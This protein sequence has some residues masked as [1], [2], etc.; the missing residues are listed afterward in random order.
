MKPVKILVPVDFSTCSI[1]ALRSAVHI[2]KRMS[3]KIF[4]SY[5]KPAMVMQSGA[6]SHFDDPVLDDELNEKFDEVIASIRDFNK[7]PHEKIARVGEV[8]EQ[9]ASLAE[10][11]GADLIV[12]GTKG[13]SGIYEVLMGS[14]TYSVV[15]TSQIP[16]LVIPD[17]SEIDEI[18]QIA[19][20]GDYKPIQPEMLNPVKLLADLDGASIHIV[21]VDDDGDLTS[22]EKDEAMKYKR[23]LKNYRH[24]YH[25]IIGQDI[26]TSLNDYCNA[27]NID[28]IAMMPRKHRLFDRVFDGGETKHMVF[29]TK[30]PLLA[31]PE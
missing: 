28:V 7:I 23:Y 5:V 13:T 17:G 2:A 11:T 25:L 12:M 3:G 26:E 20:A 31:I 9:V 6:D 14:N 21:H 18:H 29:H 22:E 15:R 19:L 1:N 4:L 27:K 10:D 30:L 16:V 24:H 8:D